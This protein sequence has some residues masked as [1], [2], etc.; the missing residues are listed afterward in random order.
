MNTLHYTIRAFDAA[1][2]TITVDFADGA[3]AHISLL[4][5]AHQ[6]P[7]NRADL[8]DIIRQFAAPVEATQPAPSLAF[9]APLIGRPMSTER[10][11]LAPPPLP[12]APPP[13]VDPLA[14]QLAEAKMMALIERVLEQRERHAV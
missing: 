14:Q 11:S 3:W 1:Q 12:P 4:S 10:R 9:V 5:A 13:A 6:M 8:E 7:A 2:Q